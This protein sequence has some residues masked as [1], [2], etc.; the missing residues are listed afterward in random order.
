MLP[1]AYDGRP[2]VTDVSVMDNGV[3]TSPGVGVLPTRPGWPRVV[4]FY[5]F[6]LS[7]LTD[8]FRSVSVTLFFF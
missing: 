4:F 8:L 7:Q 1:G 5:Y 6:K 3:L 2:D